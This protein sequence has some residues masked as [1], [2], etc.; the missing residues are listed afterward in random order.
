MR[1][2]SSLVIVANG[3]CLALLTTV[4]GQEKPAF[5]KLTL[6]SSGG[7]TGRGNGRGL[8]IDGLGNI[9]TKLQNQKSEGKLKP[10]ELKELTK[11]ITTVNW[12]EIKPAYQGK[13]ADFFQAD[14]A[15]TLNGKVH[16]THISEQVERKNLP[17]ELGELL[18]HL[19]KLY[20]QYKPGNTK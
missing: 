13:G 11:R 9:V 1:S 5:D 18:D 3:L 8:S 6:G 16:E 7:F 20:V 14:L 12:K 10:D 19:D 4:V 15:V 2:Y 17:R